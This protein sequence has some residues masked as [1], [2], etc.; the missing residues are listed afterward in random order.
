MARH[1]FRGKQPPPLNSHNLFVTCE[2]LNICQAS[3]C[4][5]GASLC[6][7]STQIPSVYVRL[8]A[9]FAISALFWGMHN[10]SALNYYL[11]AIRNT[12]ICTERRRSKRRT[13]CHLSELQPPFAALPGAVF[14][15]CF[16]C[17]GLHSEV[18]LVGLT[19]VGGP[20]QPKPGPRVSSAFTPGNSTAHA[21][22][23]ETLTSSR[24]LTCLSAAPAHAGHAVLNACMQEDYFSCTALSGCSREVHCVCVASTLRQSDSC[25]F[26]SMTFG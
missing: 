15:P 22:L 13:A 18:W 1:V 5:R 4:K 10:A 12:Y 19:A 2:C 26:A 14:S 21:W 7:A 20:N 23:P 6:L 8:S 17:D 9:P 11:P 25:S 3:V 24:R 16:C